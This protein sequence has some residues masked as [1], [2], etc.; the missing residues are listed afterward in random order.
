MPPNDLIWTIIGFTLTVLIFSYLAGDNLFF[1]FVIYAFVGMSAA[2]VTLIV[3]TQV[4]WPHVLLAIIGSS[5]QNKLVGVIGLILSILLCG[6]MVPR[7]AKF[8]NVPMGF[9]VG[10]GAA[11]AIGGSVMGTIIPQVL[12]STDISWLNIKPGDLAT[13]SPIL[14][15][16][17]ILVGTITTLAYFH[18]G[19]RKSKD[20]KPRRGIFIEGLAWIGKVCIA[21]TLGVVFT[22]VF[23]AALT[24]LIERISFLVNVIRTLV[25]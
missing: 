20:A 19:A 7:L 1:R 21:I 2:Y 24:A 18:Y 15:G 25:R 8:G 9:L 3:V 6:K 13:W 12:G 17:A 10:V 5:F 14:N 4:L 22:G 11:I 16:G 23:S